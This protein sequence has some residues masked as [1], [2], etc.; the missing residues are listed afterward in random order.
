MLELPLDI[1]AHYPYTHI[2]GR[3]RRRWPWQFAGYG[4]T[5]PTDPLGGPRGFALPSEALPW[6]FSTGLV[7]LRNALV[8]AAISVPLGDADLV[9]DG[10]LDGAMRMLG[11]RGSSFAVAMVA[12]AVVVAF[13]DDDGAEVDG[14]GAGSFAA[15]DGCG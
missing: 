8:L 6:L 9:G 10:D 14:L 12:A 4:C 15:S 11:G 5:T 3:F 7:D 13:A 2:F 1:S